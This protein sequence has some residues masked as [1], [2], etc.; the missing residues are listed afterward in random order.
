MHGLM[1][2]RRFSIAALIEAA[3]R[4]HGATPIVSHTPE[5]TIHRYTWREAH[6]RARRGG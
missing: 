3:D 2:S 5:G 4:N 6:A 1:M